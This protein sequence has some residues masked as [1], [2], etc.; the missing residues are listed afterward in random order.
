MD[1][2]GYDLPF[3]M[4]VSCAYSNRMITSIWNCNKT[5]REIIDSYNTCKKL[6]DFDIIDQYFQVNPVIPEDVTSYRVT[7]DFGTL[8]RWREAFQNSSN[9]L[10]LLTPA[11][12]GNCYLSPV[13]NMELVLEYAALLDEELRWQLHS[14][15]A[16]NRADISS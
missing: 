8:A 12:D 4:S 1:T 2:T 7:I 16:D 15:Q 10:S 3:K 13:A 9:A 6:Y 11:D 5:P 14:I